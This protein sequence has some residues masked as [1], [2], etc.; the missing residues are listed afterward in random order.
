MTDNKGIS[1]L[2]PCYNDGA[3]IRETVESVYAQRTKVPFEIL[4]IDDGSTDP[5]TQDE[6]AALNRAHPEIRTFHNVVN[7]GL[8]STRNVGLANAQYDYIF[9]LDS[10]DKLATDPTL[11]ARGGYLERGFEAFERDEAVKMFYS[12]V[13]IFDAFDHVNRTKSKFDEKELLARCTVGAF[14]MYRREDAL[15][16]GGY[17]PKMKHG[18]DWHMNIALL[19]LAVSRGQQPKVAY[20][21]DPLFCY[22]RRQNGSAM[23]SHP[24]MSVEQMLTE[25]VRNNPHIYDKHY[26]GVTGK[27]LIEAIMHDRGNI[28]KREARDLFST[29]ASHPFTAMR[30]GSWRLAMHEMPRVTRK[31]LTHLHLMAAEAPSITADDLAPV[32]SREAGLH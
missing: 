15:E 21:D 17:N 22:R 24:K 9:P 7:R 27:P 13:R 29:C 30:D 2:I 32:E 3:Y 6:V 10:D 28:L 16:V 14:A 20:A 4:I 25:I 26:P 5:F 18:E 11:L 31:V 19:N 23:T 1:I 8:P 12:R